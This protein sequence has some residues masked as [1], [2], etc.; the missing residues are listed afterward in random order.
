MCGSAGTGGVS[1]SCGRPPVNRVEYLLLTKS[2]VVS[3]LPRRGRAPGTVKLVLLLSFVCVWKS[4][5]FLE[6]A[7]GS[8]E[9]CLGAEMFGRVVFFLRS[10]IPLL[11]FSSGMM[12]DYAWNTAAMPRVE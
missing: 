12:P 10:E 7:D 11:L 8:R 4:E 1:P 2:A 3:L 6:S 5:L 9:I